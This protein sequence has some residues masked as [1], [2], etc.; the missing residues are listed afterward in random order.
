MTT[1]ATDTDTITIV[2]GRTLNN[3]HREYIACV[4]GYREGAKQSTVELQIPRSADF[5][6]VT[7]EQWADAAFV[8]TTAPG[9]V[10]VASDTAMAVHDAII[11]QA[12]AIPVLTMGDT[13][14]VD[15]VRYCCGAVGWEQR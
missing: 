1:T 5:A 9:S 15:G 4:D 7:G 3:L 13:V 14:T 11:G 8:A 2:L 12:S 6:G 10:V